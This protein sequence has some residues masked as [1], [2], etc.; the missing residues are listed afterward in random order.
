MA[1]MDTRIAGAIIEFS[2]SFIFSC[3]FSIGIIFFCF[4]MFLIFEGID[5]L[6]MGLDIISCSLVTLKGIKGRSVMILSKSE[7]WV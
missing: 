4:F 1:V 6:W 7:S 2:C 3:V 5:F